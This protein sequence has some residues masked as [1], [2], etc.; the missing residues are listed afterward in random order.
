MAESKATAPDFSLTLDVDMTL[1][2]ELRE[3]LKEQAERPPSFN[4]MVVKA[5]ALAL[6]DHPRVNGAYRDGALRAVP[7]RQRGRRGGGA[8]TR[9]WCR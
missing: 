7:A 9:S 1:C 5:V 2:I 3:R 6:R 8:R 4:D